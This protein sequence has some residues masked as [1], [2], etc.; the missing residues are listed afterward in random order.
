MK[1]GCLLKYF[2][3]P[4]AI[5]IVTAVVELAAVDFNDYKPEL[6]AHAKQAT[7]RD[8]T[9]EGDI[10][11][12]LSL[13]PSLTV[14]GVSFV[15]AKIGLAPGGGDSRSVRRASRLDLAAVGHDRRSKRRPQRSGNFAG[16]GRGWTAELCVRSYLGRRADR[17]IILLDPD[18]PYSND[19]KCARYV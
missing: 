8:L 2:V 19:R 14:S 17:A 5:L 12:A 9:V 16:D 4:V 1:I 10:E 13:T 3:G 15:N 7:G 18:N 11:L 6:A